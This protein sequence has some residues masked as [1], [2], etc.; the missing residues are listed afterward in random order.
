ITDIFF[1]PHTPEEGCDC[2]KPLPGL[3]N[4]AKAAYN[5]DPAQSLMVGDSA[6]DIECGQA[7]GVAKNI[8]VATGN[9]EKAIKTLADK[10]ITP[11]FY[12]KD[13]FETAL[14]IIQHVNPL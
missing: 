1:C 11:D 7:A 12:G 2:R 10:G 4:Q 5:I 13:L 8:L 3:I 14:W 6:K 9:G